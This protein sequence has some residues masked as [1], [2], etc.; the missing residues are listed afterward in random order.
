MNWEEYLSEGNSDVTEEYL[1]TSDFNF[2]DYY[3]EAPNCC[4]IDTLIQNENIL[5]QKRKLEEHYDKSDISLPRLEKEILKWIT[6]KKLWGRIVYYNGTHYE[7][8]TED[9]FCMYC[10]KYLPMEIQN[11]ICSVKV[12]KSLYRYVLYDFVTEKEAV[13]EDNYLISCQ[14]CVV[15]A[16]TLTTSYHSECLEVSYTVKASYIE[17]VYDYPAPYHFEQLIWNMTDGD[18][19]AM[20]LIWQMLGYVLLHVSPKRAFFWLGTEPASGKSLLCDFIQRLLG[21]ENC[22]LIEADDIGKRF[23]MA[24]FSDKRVNLGAESSG[25]LTRSDVVRIKEITG[26]KTISVEK[27]GVNREDFP[28]YTVL[29]FASNEPIFI[30]DADLTDAFWERCKLIPCMK[31]CPIEERDVNLIEKLWEERDLIVSRAIEVA[32]DLIEREFRFIEP[33]LAKQMKTAW[34]RNNGSIISNYVD[35]YL[36]IVTGNQGYFYFTPT[37]E[38][39]KHYIKHTGDVISKNS[40]SNKLNRYTSGKL[41]K[42][43]KR[44]KDYKSPVHGFYNVRIRAMEEEDDE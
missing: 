18:V 40:F 38:L 19:D 30:G 29:V 44:I 24:Q 28:N 4:D 12:F 14:N 1:E 32:S 41:I 22:S 5:E 33:Q 7:I 34:R 15:N 20:Q 42:D 35:E 43:K 23:C 11:K 36:E 27:K 31:S 16:K 3:S 13:R 9:I 25:K 6:I 17:N 8:L 37:E 10:K 26:N 2:E 21:N 39:Y